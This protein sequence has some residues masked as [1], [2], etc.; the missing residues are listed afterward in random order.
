MR[1]TALL[2]AVAGLS[3]LAGPTGVHSATAQDPTACKFVM[4]VTLSPGLSFQAGSGTF[5]SGGPTGSTLD[6]T[7]PVDGGQPTGTGT[8]AMDGRYGV[9][10]PNGCDAAVRGDG[11][12]TGVQVLAIPTAGG[13]R[14]VTNSFTFTYGGHLPMHGGFVAGMF[15]GD[16]M[17]G[18]FEF[19]PRDGSCV[20]PVTKVHVTGE[21]TL[22]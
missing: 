6:C 19:T 10:H 17:S 20:A 4:D 8:S 7:G 21:G 2:T 13:S 16:R 3:L 5:T 11:D 1:R 22:H 12:G 15:K 18:T 14:K 9:A